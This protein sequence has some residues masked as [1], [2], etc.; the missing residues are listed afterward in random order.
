M[1]KLI[2][3]FTLLVLFGSLQA[4]ITLVIDPG[5]GGTDPGNL[6]STKGL[7]QEKDLNLAIAKKLGHYVDQFLGHEVDIIYTRTSDKTVELADRVRLANSS[8][9][10]Y[11]ISIHCN[12]SVKP[13]V[14]GTETHI[15]NL[16]SQKSRDLAHQ[17]EKQFSTRAA[18]ISR[19][20]KQKSDRL[21]NLYVLRETKMPAVLVETGFMTNTDEEKYLNS[22]RGQ[23]LTASAIFRA[24]R[25]YVKAQHG[26]QMRTPNDTP[27]ELP[28]VW[29]IQIMASTG[30][31][32]LANP[33]FKSIKAEV[34]E[35]E[36]TNPTSPYNYKYYVGSFE[37]KKG[38]KDLLK[39][40]RSGRFKD[41]FLVKF[42]PNVCSH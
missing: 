40:V 6:N 11:F 15:H 8:N 30:P 2:L 29:K 25:D 21:G 17:V 18:R 23:D 16:K 33:D 38:A 32:A 31:V 13:D 35:V 7:L 42:D 19:G 3:L 22:D 28:V 26:I 9:A 4:K 37:D 20:V 5:H 1:K 24:F 12:S 14:C 39:E 41:A 10:T 27:K 34:E 36:I